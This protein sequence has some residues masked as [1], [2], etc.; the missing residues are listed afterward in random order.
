MLAVGGIGPARIAPSLE[1]EAYA[2]GG[3]VGFRSRD[4][5]ADGKISLLSPLG[6][7]PVRL[8]ASLSGGAQP[9]VERLDIGPEL[10]IRLPLKPVGARLSIEWRERIAG[11]AAPT[12]GPALTLGADF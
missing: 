4:L 12:S 5:F 1:V 9:Q 2:Q 3:M 10:Q 7:S 8:G 6:N 11:G